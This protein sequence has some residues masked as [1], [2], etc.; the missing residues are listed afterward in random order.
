MY[1]KSKG[2][3]FFHSPQKQ[4]NLMV[5]TFIAFLLLI[6]EK[7]I[8]SANAHLHSD[9]LYF[10]FYLSLT[11]VMYIIIYTCVA[12]LLALHATYKHLLIPDFF[13]LGIKVYH[14]FFDSAYLIKNLNALSSVQQ[15]D[16]ICTIVESIIF[17]VFL[18]LLFIGKLMHTSRHYHKV[19]PFVC[20]RLLIFCFP[21]TV[22]LQCIKAWL[23]LG[24]SNHTFYIIFN[25]IKNILN[26]AF[27]DL[28]YFL[29]LLLLAFVP[30]K[31]YHKE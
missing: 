8:L 19:Y 23:A 31:R 20:M 16:Y 10:E 1:Q 30:E 26:E 5:A 22:I 24:S 29:L 7:S 28:P 3:L 9:G 12:V 2:Y 14:V 17:S 11:D 25:L 6:A 13:L 18:I 27:L 21:I 4:H 15:M